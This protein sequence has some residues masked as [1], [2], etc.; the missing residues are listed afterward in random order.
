MNAA[1]SVS[2]LTEGNTIHVSLTLVTSTQ[3][4]LRPVSDVKTEV[5]AVISC[6][7]RNANS[8][9]EVIGRSQQTF[10]YESANSLLVS[11]STPWAC[12]PTGIQATSTV[13]DPVTSE[14]L[15]DFQSDENEV[16]TDEV[17]LSDTVGVQEV[18]SEN[19]LATPLPVPDIPGPRARRFTFFPVTMGE[20]KRK[21]A[22]HQ[23]QTYPG[24][25]DG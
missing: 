16:I 3:V 18:R 14:V 1:I 24:P 12:N 13:E 21:P 23:K 22:R 6:L 4:D 7:E 11:T 20:A 17:V 10:G 5:D 8:A 15:W 19:I 25:T 9:T 2:R